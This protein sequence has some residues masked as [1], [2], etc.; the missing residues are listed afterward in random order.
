MMEKA[1]TM[2]YVFQSVDIILTTG[3][4]EDEEVIE[5]HNEYVERLRQ[6]NGIVEPSSESELLKLANTNTNTNNLLIT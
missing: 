5:N 4:I 1:T 3:R 2:A 6:K